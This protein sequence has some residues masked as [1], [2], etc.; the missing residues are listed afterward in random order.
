[1]IIAEATSASVAYNTVTITHSDVWDPNS[2]NNTARTPT[3]PQQADLVL[4]KTVDTA[5]PEVNDQVTFTLTLENLGPT[6]AQNVT[7]DDRL[8][9]GL[10]FVSA[11]PAGD[12]NDSTGVWTVGTLAAQATE[13][14]T[15]TARVLEPTGAGPVSA[16]TN[17]GTARSTT[18][19]PNPGNNTDRATVTPLQADLA[20]AKT[21]SSSRPQIG[22]TFSYTIEVSNL[23]PDTASNASVTDQLPAGVTYVSHTATTGSYDVG[24]GVWTIGSVTTADRPVLTITALV[25]IGNSGGPVTNT[26]TV[27]SGTWDP[28]ETNNTSSVTVVVPP[29]GV[30]VGTDV[31]CVTGPFVRVIDPDTGAN[32]ITPF[33][34]YEPEFRGGV[35]V[36]GA[37]VTGDGI[38]EIITAPGPAR[39]TPVAL[40]SLRAR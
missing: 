36:Y 33:F 10:A 12:Y 26:A 15:I 22:S 31:G 2:S 3:D 34:A 16:S 8:P 27:T 40:R 32:R 29:R 18:V 1:M 9:A 11:N 30:I 20:V 37:D 5:R 25:T 35:R 24:T 13:I 4:T 19:D 38:P 14:L 23:G 28:D 39:A 21:A 7:V 17:T 6:A